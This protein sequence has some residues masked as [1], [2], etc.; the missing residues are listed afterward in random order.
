MATEIVDLPIRNSD[1]PVRYVGLP[2]GNRVLVETNLPS[3]R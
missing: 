1:F 3:P 2:E